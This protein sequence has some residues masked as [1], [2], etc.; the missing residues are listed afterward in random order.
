MQ[1][2]GVSMLLTRSG[3]LGAWCELREDFRNFRLD[4]IEKTTSTRETFRSEPP[5]T[6]ED[7]MRAMTRDAP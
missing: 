4:R 2:A 6:I 7:Y 5:L 1:L 3:T